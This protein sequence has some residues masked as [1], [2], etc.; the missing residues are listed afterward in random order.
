MTAARAPMVHDDASTR[1][2]D[3]AETVL[4]LTT[5]TSRGALR[6]RPV[7]TFSGR[8]PAEIL[9]LT[10]SSA[11]KVRDVTV[12]PA[13][14]LAGPVP[15]GWFAAEGIAT[16]DHRPAAVAELLHRIGPPATAD[17]VVVLRV[18]L[19]R[20]RRW[21]TASSAPWDNSCIEIP[22]GQNAAER[23]QAARRGG[24]EP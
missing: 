5:T 4:L 19:S 15:G 24:L 11:G 23:R 16:V 3:I 9:V 2:D 18:Q 17:Q 8:T 21:E 6:S 10:G 20:A 1:H 22:L 14:S 7:T 13:V 12:H